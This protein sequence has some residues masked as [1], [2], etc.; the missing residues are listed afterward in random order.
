[1]RSLGDLQHEFDRLARQAEVLA[2]SARNVLHGLNDEPGAE[3]VI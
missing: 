1:M 3:W 2:R